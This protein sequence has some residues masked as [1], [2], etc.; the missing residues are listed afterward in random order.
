[1]QLEEAHDRGNPN[2]GMSPAA[3][4]SRIAGRADEAVREF[5]GEVEGLAL[6][7][8]PA[9]YD[10]FGIGSVTAALHVTGQSVEAFG[11]IRLDDL[12]SLVLEQARHTRN[13]VH[14]ERPLPTQPVRDAIDRLEALDMHGQQ[15]AEW[16]VGRRGIVPVVRRTGL[17]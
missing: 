4:W 6:D 17:C 3:V 14:P 10:D 9:G 1:M 12:D 8:G 7:T 11:Q 15:S 16:F 5:I 2:A 13:R